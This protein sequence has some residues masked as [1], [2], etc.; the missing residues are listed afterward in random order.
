[1]A[2]NFNYSLLSAD[3]SLFSTIP[4]DVLPLIFKDVL[5][6][7]ADKV[8]LVCKPWQKFI[9][10]PEFRHAFRPLR[11]MGVKELKTINLK[12]VDAGIERPLPRCAYRDYA[13]KSIWFVFDPGKVKV[14]DDDGQIVEVALNT[15]KAIGKLCNIEF[16]NSWD[17]AL[18]EERKEEPPRWMRIDTKATGFSQN[19]ETQ[20]ETA[21]EEDKKNYP[22]R[23]V[24]DA[25][26]S[27][28]EQGKPIQIVHL[29]D[30]KA[31]ALGIS[32]AKTL[33]NETPFVWD[34]ANGKWMVI[35]TITLTKDPNGR[36]WPTVVSFAPPGLY[37]PSRYDFASINVGFV[38]ARKSF[39]T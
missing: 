5:P 23:Y 33:F 22:E 14:E 37:V 12:I 13:D 21:R 1:M 18:R 27:R 2:A 26:V 7:E 8:A 39:G 10:S 28:D 31:L 25:K 30:A 24:A 4:M 34:P 17:L 19:Y 9:D 20:Q 38:F 15:L 32:M 11:A 6:S 36:A 16:I 3:L 35:R 29:A